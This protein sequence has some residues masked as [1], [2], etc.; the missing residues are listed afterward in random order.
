MKEMRSKILLG[1]MLLI[2]I[3]SN[4]QGITPV[5]YDSEKQAIGINPYFDGWGCDFEID[6][7]NDHSS[8]GI[9]FQNRSGEFILGE[10]D[11]LTDLSVYKSVPGSTSYYYGSHDCFYDSL[12]GLS[13]LHISTNIIVDVTGAAQN[14]GD[15]VRYFVDEWNVAELRTIIYAQPMNSIGSAISVLESDLKNIYYRVNSSDWQPVPEPATLLLLGL[16]GM[17][18]RRRVSR[19]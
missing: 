13:E 5:F 8:A 6:F 7:N 9:I 14:R 17:I 10:Y 2:F 3:V 12:N 15:L 18:L 4:S 19:R 1:C 11:R 16:G